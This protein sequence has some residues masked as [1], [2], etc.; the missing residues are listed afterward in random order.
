MIGFEISTQ[1]AC[2][3]AALA[4]STWYKKPCSKDW[5]LL[6][7]RFRDL[8]KRHLRYGYRRLHIMLK[9][10]GWKVNHKTVQ[11]IYLEEGL[12]LRTKT[13]AAVLRVARA[14]PTAVNEF[15]SMDFVHDELSN[16]RRFR[17]LT[18]VDNFSRECPVIEVDVSLRS[19]ALIT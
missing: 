19:H 14:A 7:I 11:K 12:S 1:R 16:G 10:E 18:I 13:R 2:E 3:L 15:W 5:T 17:C 6:R 9:R 4:R 8:A